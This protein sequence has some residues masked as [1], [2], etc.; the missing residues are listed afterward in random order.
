VEAGAIIGQKDESLSCNRREIP[1]T[2]D[3]TTKVLLGLIAAGLWANV[4]AAQLRPAFAQDV[5]L[6][7]IEDDLHRIAR[8]TCLNSK[9]C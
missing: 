5:D 4:V 9:I 1:M 3:R 8:G 6:S 2:M 7:T